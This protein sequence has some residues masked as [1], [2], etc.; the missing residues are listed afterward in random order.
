MVP[1]GCV[2]SA[3]S[4]G[5][6]STVYGPRGMYQQC[7]V[8]GVWVYSL[9]SQGDGSTVYGSRGDGSTMH[10]LGGG[11]GLQFM[12][13]G[14]WVNN[15]WSGGMGLQFMVPGGWV[16]SAWCGRGQDQRGLTTV[17]RM[18]HT[19]ENVT[20]PWI[21]YV[22]KIDD[23][24]SAQPACFISP[25][26]SFKLSIYG[27]NDCSTSLSNG[28]ASRWIEKAGLYTVSRCHTRGESEDHTS[29]KA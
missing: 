21:S 27:I 8:W 10:G 20:F 12:V 26:M 19:S 11:M 18:T 9:W 25:R 23:M 14:G 7:M 22:G 2:N 3:W 5:Y 29:K 15:A 28:P 1:G 16:N 24:M 17:N 6:G 13:P 4:G